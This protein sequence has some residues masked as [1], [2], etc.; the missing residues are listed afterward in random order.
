[1]F[2]CFYFFLKNAM[3]SQPVKADVL[4]VHGLLGAAF[5]TWRQQDRDQPLD[6]STS[7]E[8]DYTECWPKVAFE[9]S[10]SICS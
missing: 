9:F 3:F 2:S 4:F 10:S 5:K 8:D 7:Q 6:E 1:M